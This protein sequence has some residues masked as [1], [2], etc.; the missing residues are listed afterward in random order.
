MHWKPSS[1]SEHGW[2]HTNLKTQM[3]NDD[4]VLDLGGSR[5]RS[6]DS[7]RHKLRE[8]MQHDR[9]ANAIATVPT[10]NSMISSMRLWS[11]YYLSVEK[12]MWHGAS[13]PEK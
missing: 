1:T 8:G 7:P 6:A 9:R 13:L 10:N 5:V 11:C 2:L 3:S 4:R 12:S